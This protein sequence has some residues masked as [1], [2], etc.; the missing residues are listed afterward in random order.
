MYINV[1]FS[2]KW[3]RPTESAEYPPPFP[4]LVLLHIYLQSNIKYT[5]CWKAR[6]I[7]TGET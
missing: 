2:E 5:V 6:R 3:M 4:D 7:Y 1:H